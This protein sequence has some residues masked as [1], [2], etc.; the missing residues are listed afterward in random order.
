MNDTSEHIIS[1]LQRKVGSLTEELLQAY[2]ELNLMYDMAEMFSSL[3]DFDEVSKTVL[4]EA[5]EF[6]EADKGWLVIFEKE[7]GTLTNRARHGV[8][9]QACSFFNA[10]LVINVVS[11]GRPVLIN[12]VREQFGLNGD[13]SW[14]ETLICL[15]LKTKEEVLGAIVLGRDT[16][17]HIFTAGDLKLMKVLCTQSASAIKTAHLVYHLQELYEKLREHDRVRGALGRYLPSQLVDKVIRGEERLTL[18]GELVHVSVLFADIRGFTRI[19]TTMPPKKVVDLLNRYFAVMI[20][21]VFAYEGTLDKIMGDAV[22]AIFGAPVAHEETEL[23]AV[24]AG[25]MMQKEIRKL[26]ETLIS[27]G[28]QPINV[29]IGISTGEVICGNVGSQDRMEFTVMGDPVNVAFRLQNV[30]NHEQVLI[31]ESTFIA[32]ENRLDYKT[33]EP[34]KFKGKDKPIGIYE[35]LTVKTLQ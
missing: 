24:Q 20:D 19:M 5:L 18:G 6:L 11:S 26:N 32:I 15:P 27:E 28:E 34:I 22:M 1:K 17:G 29:G 23:R 21:S 12:N 33:H 13:A 3:T 31:T 35:A 10:N 7:S 4:G 25:L 16:V 14:P 8:N 30:A 9:L 2:E